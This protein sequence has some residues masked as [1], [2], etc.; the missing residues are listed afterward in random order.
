MAL[1]GQSLKGGNRDSQD[2]KHTIP[3]QSHEINFNFDN[4]EI[5]ECGNDPT[6]NQDGENQGGTDR[7]LIYLRRGINPVD[8][9]PRRLT[10]SNTIHRGSLANEP[11]GNAKMG[12]K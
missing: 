1:E 12:C 8:N 3:L 10:A 2:H 9:K 4:R 11:H 6:E 7:L 5:T